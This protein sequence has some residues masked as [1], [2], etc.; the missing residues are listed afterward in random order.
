VTCDRE[1]LYFVSDVHLG[2]SPP[3]EE[4]PKRAR[5]HELLDRVE[6]DRAALVILGDLF[7]F[8]FEY[9]TVIPRTAFSLLARLDGM[10]RAGTPVLYLGGN[11][12]FWMTDFLARETALAVLADGTVLR[13]QERRL[14][15][16]HGD[17]RGPGDRGYKVL[18]AVLRNP[19]AIRM[20]R[21]IHPDLGIR[22]ALGSSH[23]SREATGGHGVDVEALFREVGLPELRGD[24]DAFLMGHHHVPVH[25]KRPEGEFLILGDWFRRFTYGRLREGRLELL[26]WDSDRILGES[27]D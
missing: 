7:D 22:L 15:L 11:H 19:L 17:G 27:L 3:D 2:G 5:L 18:K 4:G 12:D 9:R 20:F 14:Y 26:E 10:A 6:A 24:V 21:W 1:T 16:A 23:A 8:W 25:L 13:A